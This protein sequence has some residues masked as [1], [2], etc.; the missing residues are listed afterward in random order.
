MIYQTDPEFHGHPIHPFGCYFLALVAALQPRFNS[1]VEWQFNHED[2]L[3]L[4]DRVVDDGAMLKD[5]TVQRGADVLELG[6][7]WLGR[8][9]TWKQMV[10][11]TSPRLQQ[12]AGEDLN[13]YRSGKIIV[14]RY[15]L[16]RPGESTWVHFML[17]KPATTDAYG[18]YGVLYDPWVYAYAGKISRTR[19]EGKL[20]G[21]RQYLR[22]SG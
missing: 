6:A 19:R 4:Y 10:G 15:V 11:Q 22:K 8:R 3:K 21:V 1:E 20:Q 5:C 2:V 12:T 14:A 16:Q 13:R 17:D 9:E 7:D 18:A